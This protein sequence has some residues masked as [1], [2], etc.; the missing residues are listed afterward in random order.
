MYG[1]GFYEPES[2]FEVR[3]AL[4][5]YIDESGRWQSIIDLTDSEG[6]LWGLYSILDPTER[7]RPRKR[8]WG[9]KT[10]SSVNRKETH[11]ETGASG[12]TTGLPMD[13]SILWS[14]DL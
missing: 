2:A 10:A 12:T 8:Y 5:D 13:A 9:P 1:Y 3:P 11:L 14:L 7:M 4:C 6:L